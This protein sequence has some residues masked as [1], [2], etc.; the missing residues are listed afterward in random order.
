M[1]A[2]FCLPSQY[3]WVENKG[4]VLSEGPYCQRYC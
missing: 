2:D 4:R 1:A 3:R